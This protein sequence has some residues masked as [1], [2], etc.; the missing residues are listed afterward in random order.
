MEGRIKRFFPGGSTCRGYVSFFDHILPW[1]QASKIFVIKGG[2]GVGK[3]TFIREIGERISK[4]GIDIEFLHCSADSGSLDG[5]VIPRYG[6][7]LIDGTAPHVIDP[8]YPGCVDEIINLGDFWDETGIRK[9][10]KDMLAL[11]EEI[12]RCYKRGFGYLKAAKTVFDEMQEIYSWSI[13]EKK[14]CQTCEEVINKVFSDVRNKEKVSR[15]RHLFAS[16]IA[17]EGLVNFLDNLFEGVKER[18]ILKGAPVLARTR[19]LNAVLDMALMKGLDVEIFHCP[20]SPERVEHIIIKDLNVGFITSV[21][22]HVLSQEKPDDLIINFDEALTD[23]EFSR[24]VDDVEY[25]RKIL[26]ELLDKAV[27]C[28]GRAKALHDRLE[29]FYITNMDYN[30]INRK[31]ED[32]YG[33]I[34]KLIDSV[35]SE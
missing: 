7:A 13:D 20:L 19:L 8:K 15:Q 18:F 6:I 33:A 16:A 21:E 5:V 24:Y 30:R 22:P 27:G 9:H 12:S 23:S 34:I 28:F 10:K 29:S 35:N 11:Q 32:T 3:S 2:P 17:P 31:M 4:R 14:V 26:A 25:Y 1:A